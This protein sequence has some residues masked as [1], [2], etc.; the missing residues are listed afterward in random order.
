MEPIEFSSDPVLCKWVRASY[1]D[2]DKLIKIKKQFTTNKPFPHLALEQF[3]IPAKIKQVKLALQ[4]ESFINK[5]A[6]L[7][8]FQQTND[9]ITT[10]NRLLRDFRAFL[11]SSSCMQYLEYISGLALKRNTLDMAGTLYTDT[12]YLLCHDDQLE[13]R[14][15]AYLIYLSTLKKGEGGELDLFSSSKTH[16]KSE[17]SPT[18]VGKSIT[19]KEGTFMFF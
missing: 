17:I 14:S 15:I 9:L 18:R 5:N 10:K 4:K 19:P 16:L 11:I 1:L 6:D 12:D 7:F 2:K 3:F 8:S 13:G